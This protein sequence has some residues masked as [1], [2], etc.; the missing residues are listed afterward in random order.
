MSGQIAWQ[1]FSSCI[2]TASNTF[3]D[4]R[5]LMSRVYFPRF[6]VPLAHMISQTVTLLI[7]SA[8]FIVFYLAIR[9]GGTD[10]SPD[11]TIALVPLYLLHLG[12]LGLGAGTLLSSFTT[13]YRDAIILIEYGITLWMYITPVLYD[14]SSL[15]DWLMQF[16]LLNPLTPVFIHLQT[17]LYGGGSY[18]WG[19]YLLSLGVSLLLLLIGHRVFNRA[20]LTFLDTI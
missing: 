14:Y 2:N 8:I 10:V 1:F 7:K 4:N 5:D 19:Y 16:Y 13:K 6:A 17:A 15:P 9:L 20:A 12:I 18:Y 3:F 11:H